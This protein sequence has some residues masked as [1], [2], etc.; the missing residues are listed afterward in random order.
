MY[1]SYKATLLL[2]GWNNCYKIPRLPSQTWWTVTKYLLHQWQWI[3]SFI[4][5][6]FSFFYHRED[7]YRNWLYT[8]NTVGVLLKIGP[9]NPSRTS[10][11][12]PGVLVRSDHVAYFYSFLW[13]FVFSFCFVC[14]HPVSCLRNVASVPGLSVLGKNTKQYAKVWAIRAPQITE[15]EPINKL[16]VCTNKEEAMTCQTHLL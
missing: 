11:F 8:S 2:G 4:R 12:I 10:A 9:S 6:F 7:F 5:R 14:L 3:F 15:G 1:Y 16:R 13:C